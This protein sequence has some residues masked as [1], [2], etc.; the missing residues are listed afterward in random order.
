MWL[1]LMHSAGHTVSVGMR[2]M[3]ASRVQETIWL[4]CGAKLLFTEPVDANLMQSLN[5][6]DV[7]QSG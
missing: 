2:P 1:R 6:N 4:Y 7:M 3:R 5:D